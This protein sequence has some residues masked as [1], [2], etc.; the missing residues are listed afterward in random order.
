VIATKLA[1]R[2]Q[3]VAL[4][5]V[6]LLG[7][8]LTV[9]VLGLIVR[10]Q[11]DK[12]LIQR[13]RETIAVQTIVEGAV[14]RARAR[15][16]AA[17]KRPQAEQNFRASQADLDLHGVA[18]DDD[19]ALLTTPGG[20]PIYEFTVD[21]DNDSADGAD[22][23]DTPRRIVRYTLRLEKTDYPNH[24]ANSLLLPPTSAPTSE[25]ST[26]GK[27]LACFS[28]GVLAQTDYQSDWC[29]NN[30]P[31]AGGV[32]AN[33]ALTQYY[34]VTAVLVDEPGRPWAG[35]QTR[36]K[37]SRNS[38]FRGKFAV[39][40]DNLEIFP[41]GGFTIR[42][43]IQSNANLFIGNGVNLKHLRDVSDP[44][45]DSTDSNVNTVGQIYRHRLHNNNTESDV[46]IDVQVGDT[47]QT[48]SLTP[49]NDSLKVGASLSNYNVGFLN[50]YDANG[51][52]ILT[53]P[54]DRDVNGDGLYQY[55]ETFKGA[56]GAAGANEWV[57]D[58]D[59]VQSYTGPN[60]TTQTATGWDEIA[61][62]YFGGRLNTNAEAYNVPGA[63]KL[64][65]NNP[66]NTSINS[67]NVNGLRVETMTGTSVA[68]LPANTSNLSNGETVIWR[69]GEAI[70]VISA[71][72]LTEWA[73]VN[74]DLSTKQSNKVVKQITPRGS[75]ATGE[76]CN[77]NPPSTLSF[78]PVDTASIANAGERKFP[79]C[80]FYN[81]SFRDGR[82]SANSG[83]GSITVTNINVGNLSRSGLAPASGLIYATRFDAVA[84][85][86]ST[87]VPN[88]IRIQNASVLPKEAIVNDALSGTT[89][90]KNPALKCITPT[91]FNLTTNDPLYVQG[92]FNTKTSGGSNWI[93]ASLTSDAITVLSNNW[94]DADNQTGNNNFATFTEINA[95]IVS[96]IVASKGS[97]YS[98]GLENFFRLLE[99]WS[100]SN[101][102][103][104]T[105][106]P[107][108]KKCTLQ[109]KGTIIQQ[110][111]SRFATGRWGSGYYSVPELRDWGYDLDL[112]PQP[113]DIFSAGLG[114]VSV[115][116]VGGP[117]GVFQ[118]TLTQAQMTGIS[119][120]DRIPLTEEP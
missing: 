85:N 102:S 72:G 5:T 37:V 113:D 76:N 39:Y 32:I 67:A 27:P 24:P 23:T 36:I 45:F 71:D 68:T 26:F 40:R 105:A 11:G 93:P 63:D 92:T 9:L 57:V 109:F 49:N 56:G 104:R 14:G 6:I 99:N 38:N 12:S 15:I 22:A 50:D 4:I 112:L 55:G 10:T 78:S 120:L 13:G 35:L 59:S 17:F 74:T 119:T 118:K 79:K 60:G 2:R 25:V 44:N 117:D 28:S 90:T 95:V 18:F 86:G 47:L 20:V 42:G 46:N 64:D 111:T 58:T 89:C 66:E 75:R 80:T 84:G 51:D 69:D 88:G 8:A 97:N 115:T 91:N 34:V 116:T 98:G 108:G 94:R 21:H 82:E 54:G 33:L 62:E 41:G 107:G 106:S 83:P 70:A 48:R 7:L 19:I 30:G 100:G 43:G 96:G 65:P 101:P 110:W 61:K 53:D 73:A 3:G 1:R 114:G 52:G 81:S 31:T 103:C 29:S 87:K 16:A 77:T